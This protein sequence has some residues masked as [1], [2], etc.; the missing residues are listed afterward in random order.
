VTAAVIRLDDLDAPTAV[1]AITALGNLAA[2]HGLPAYV[3]AYPTATGV[4]IAATH[5]T[6]PAWRAAL[7][8][9]AFTEHPQTYT[10]RY[11]TETLWF[12]IT[13]KLSYTDY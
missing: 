8:A 7:G 10:T 3:K 13:V 5:D 4:H 6:A 11:T 9:P 2:L 12:G 1:P